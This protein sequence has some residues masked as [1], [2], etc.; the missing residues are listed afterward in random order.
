MNY[1]LI[2]IIYMYD[3]IYAY[4]YIY[5]YIY[6]YMCVCLCVC[7]LYKVWLHPIR[8]DN[9]VSVAKVAMQ[10]IAFTIRQIMKTKY[11]RSAKCNSR[12]S[13]RG[14]FPPSMTHL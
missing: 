9:I 1:L 6:I 4:I 3:N 5:I 11:Q 14:Y 10:F 7:V 12:F 13:K 8:D 2:Y